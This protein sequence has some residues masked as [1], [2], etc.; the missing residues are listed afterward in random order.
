MP[1]SKKYLHPESIKRISRMEL[2]ARHIVEGF[3]SGMHRS[4]YFGQ[5]IEFRQHREYVAG[6]DLRHVD[7]QVWA[8]QDRLY[9]KQYEEDT[10]LRCTLLVDI[11]ASMSYGSGPLNKYEYGCTAAASLAY[12][13]LKQQDAVGAASFDERIRGR[14]PVRSK[15]NHLNSI[16]ESFGSQSLTDK[17]DM[18]VVLSQAAETFARRGM[19][20]VVSDLLTDVERLLQGLRLLRQLGHDVLVFHINDSKDSNRPIR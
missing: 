13:A 4:P 17:T 7:W 18:H 19:M 11:S 10:N 2:R 9:I 8:R 20:V 14:V 5:S 16:I 15:R 3:L 1:D 6:D 12:L